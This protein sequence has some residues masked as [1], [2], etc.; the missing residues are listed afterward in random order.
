MLRVYLDQNHWVSLLKARVG[1]PDGERFEDTWLLLREA[2]ARGWVST[3]LS[4][5]H[6]EMH[7]RRNYQSRVD[8]AI[9][10]LELSHRHAIAPPR[11]LLPSEIDRALKSM[12]GR[13]VVP[14]PCQVFGVGVNHAVGKPITDYE[15]PEGALLTPEERLAFRRRGSQLKEVAALVGV[16]PGFEPPGYDPWAARRVG[17]EFAAEQEQLRKL[18]RPDGFDRGDRGRRAACVDVFGEFESMFSEA[19]TLAGLH[20][21][22]A[23]AQE[24]EGLEELLCATPTVFAHRE[25]RRLRHEASSKAWEAGDLV[26]LTALASALVY[27]DVVVTERVWTHFAMRA[28]LDQ[29]FGTIVL[30]DLKSLEPYLISAA[31]AAA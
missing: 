21:G 11:K 30:R 9:T 4:S 25:L 23:Y 19:L 15:P 29:R 22:H 10:M 8:L 31:H 7:H 28:K 13:P 20:W 5:H 14:R 27:C 12:F 17:E 3:P 16:R 6:L 2:V 18:R 24:A 1:H 26:D